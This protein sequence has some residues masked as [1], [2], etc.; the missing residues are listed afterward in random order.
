MTK[1]ISGVTMAL[2]IGT[3]E[4]DAFPFVDRTAPLT[5]EAEGRHNCSSLVRSD[6]PLCWPAVE[7]DNTASFSSAVRLML[8]G[9]LK[10]LMTLK[11]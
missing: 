6:G 11:T 7:A 2:T 5:G 10:P 8:W 1:V 4:A 9:G 3:L